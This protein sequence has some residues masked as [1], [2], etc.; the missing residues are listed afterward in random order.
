MAAAE[1]K[2][3]AKVTINAYDAAVQGRKE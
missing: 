3:R 2:E 1:V